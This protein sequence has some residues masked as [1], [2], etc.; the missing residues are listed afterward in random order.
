MLTIAIVGKTNVGKTTF[1]NAA[2]LL[3]AKISNYAFTTTEPNIGTAYASDTCVC[4]ELDIKDNPQE[5]ACIDGWRYIPIKLIDIPGLI[6]DAWKGRGLGNKFLSAIGQADALIHVVDAS[7]SVDEEGKITKPGAGNPLQD[8]LDIEIEIEKWVSDIVTDNRQLITREAA[9][10][11]LEEAMS[12]AIAGVKAKIPSIEEAIKLAGLEGVNFEKWRQ[13]DIT[14]FVRTLLP[15]AKPTMIVANKMDLY[16]AEDNFENL[17]QYFSSGLVTACSAEAELALRRAQKAGLLRYT[18]GSEKFTIIE[19]AKLSPEQGRALDYVDRRIMSKWMR[20]G[21]Q[22][23]LNAV[24]FKLLKM[25]MVYPVADEHNFSDKHG[26][27]LPHAHLLPDGSTPLD[28]A[29]EVHTRLVEQY[30]LAL[31]AK[32]GMRLPKDYKLR[33]RDVVKIMT[34]PRANK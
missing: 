20:T 16:L 23:A 27:V 26:N 21:I 12:L 18:P 3:D 14:H 7:G 8:A 33:H 24:V 10:L 11:P 30:T 6:K 25:N 9:R 4:R 34:Q 22:Q 28:L 13:G 2:T 19:G 31:D 5:S 32:T 17:S 1:F 15:L 29:G